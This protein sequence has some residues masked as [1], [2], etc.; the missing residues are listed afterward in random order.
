MKKS[1]HTVELSSHEQSVVNTDRRETNNVLDAS[2]DYSC[3]K[4]NTFRSQMSKKDKTEANQKGQKIYTL[5]SRKEDHM[6]EIAKLE[7]EIESLR[8]EKEFD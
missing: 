7:K 4:D 1:G 3:K 2:L 6:N 5:L 8:E